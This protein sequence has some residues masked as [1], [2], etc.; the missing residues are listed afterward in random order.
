MV[1]RHS[2]DLVQRLRTLP[3]D[4]ED[5]PWMIM[6]DLQWHAVDVLLSALR[7]YVR[8]RRRP[9]YLASYLLVQTELPEGGRLPEVAPDVLMVDAVVRERS[10]W[11]VL[12]EGKPPQF[13]LEVTSRESMVRD[14]RE[15][16]SI[17]D[18]MGVEEYAI[19]YP[20]RPHGPLLW[21]Y[22]RAADGSFVPWQPTDQGWLVSGVLDG[23]TLY[24]EERRWL[25]LLDVHGQRLP[26]A[27]E[28]RDVHVAR[29]RAEAARADAEAARA[30]VEGAARAAAEA[31]AARLRGELERLHHPD[32]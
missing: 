22:H 1:T 27:Q 25:R 3:D 9:W 12:E 26:T 15:K 30:D 29:A 19:F 8:E 5:A 7:L 23:M 13:V 16:V 20:R 18:L 28:D 10:S 24:V 14:A 21:G 2:P 31:D 11:N 6:A 17:Y 32:H 4:T